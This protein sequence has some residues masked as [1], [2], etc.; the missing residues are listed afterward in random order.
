MEVGERVGGDA[1][2]IG[3]KYYKDHAKEIVT[4]TVDTTQPPFEVGEKFDKLST[5]KLKPV[6]G[7]A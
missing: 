3:G 5:K 4:E 6:N 1:E 2:M 7:L